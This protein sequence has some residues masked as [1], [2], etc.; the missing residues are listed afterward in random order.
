MQYISCCRSNYTPP[1]KH[2][3]GPV[4]GTKRSAFP[5]GKPWQYKNKVYKP[6]RELGGASSSGVQ[7]SSLLGSLSSPLSHSTPQSRQRPIP[8]PSSKLYLPPKPAARQV[9]DLTSASLAKPV[10]TLSKTSRVVVQTRS[11]KATTIKVEVSS[12]SACRRVVS[13]SPTSQ[14]KP[15]DARVKSSRVVV[16]ALPVPPVTI[17]SE[18]SPDPP[19]SN[20]PSSSLPSSYT[21]TSM[22]PSANVRPPSNST[23]GQ[24][25][26]LPVGD[27]PAAK[28]PLTSARS[29]LK[30]AIQPPDGIRATKPQ[31]TLHVQHD[32]GMD[33][34]RKHHPM[35]L[36]DR[37]L[38]GNYGGTDFSS[39]ERVI[40]DV[41]RPPL[42]NGIRP[43]MPPAFS[44]HPS[45]ASVFNAPS[46]SGNTS[47][48]H[49]PPVALAFSTPNQS[50]Q[51]NQSGSKSSGKT[52]KRGKRGRKK[53]VGKGAAKTT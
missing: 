48:P 37:L 24:S 50:N 26:A 22:P 4:V 40:L 13:C 36:R 2:T 12:S 19:S 9:V 30:N 15:V 33:Q 28:P 52:H 7:H 8:N 5:P 38:A 41:T 51:S 35:V 3:K 1:S 47:M 17:K 23:A 20:P 49:P 21:S 39:G 44:V 45:T 6:P 25:G 42:L 34:N 16:K 31:G 46:Q 29:V 53:S 32:A 27:A 10:D 14:V 43:L 11:V 18:P